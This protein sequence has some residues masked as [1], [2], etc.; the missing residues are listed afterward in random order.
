MEEK[1]KVTV[2]LREST[3]EVLTEIARREDRSQ[4]A[5]VERAILLYAG[6]D[7]TQQKEVER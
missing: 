7:E 6:C 5:V 3:Y 2:L 1:K 4:R